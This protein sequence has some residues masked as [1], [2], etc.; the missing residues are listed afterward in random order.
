MQVTKHTSEGSTLA[1][2]PRVEVHNKVR[3]KRTGALHFVLKLVRRSTYF[4]PFVSGCAV[5]F[6]FY[7]RRRA[8]QRLCQHILKR[9][10]K[11][12]NGYIHTG[13]MLNIYTGSRF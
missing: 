13:E 6:V 5:E 12:R 4:D 2:K 10:C 11:Q 8:S 7:R 9:N 1:L 3:T